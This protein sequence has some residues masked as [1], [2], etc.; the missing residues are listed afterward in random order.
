MRVQK[1]IR[2]YKDDKHIGNIKWEHGTYSLTKH[3]QILEQY[4]DYDFYSYEK[5]DD[6]EDNHILTS[7]DYINNCYFDYNTVTKEKTKYMYMPDK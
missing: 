3:N 7:F 1:E 4:G 2:V 6:D 5:Q